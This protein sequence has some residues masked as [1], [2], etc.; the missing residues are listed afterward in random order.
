ML[1]V[2]EEIIRRATHRDPLQRFQTLDALEAVLRQALRQPLALIHK[3]IN[4]L[5]KAE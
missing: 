5:S 1:P 3:P 4:W 2:L